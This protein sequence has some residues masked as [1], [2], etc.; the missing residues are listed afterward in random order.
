[1]NKRT[2]KVSEPRGIKKRVESWG[3]RTSE[4]APFKAGATARNSGR[5]AG[6]EPRWEWDAF[7][8]F[9]STSTEKKRMKKT[10]LI[11]KFSAI[12]FEDLCMHAYMNASYKGRRTFLKKTQVGKK[13]PSLKVYL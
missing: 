9:P 10:S 11:L 4:A 13:G 2:L 5:L 7:K 1:M 12:K 8:P 6:K 3:A